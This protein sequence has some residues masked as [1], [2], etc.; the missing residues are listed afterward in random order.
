VCERAKLLIS[1]RVCV[2]FGLF[3]D[4]FPAVRFSLV[5]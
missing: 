3:L 1:V 5:F 2:D 4:I